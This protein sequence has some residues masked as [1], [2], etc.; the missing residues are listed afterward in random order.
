MSHRN[1]T[2]FSKAPLPAVQTGRIS[3]KATQPNPLRQ[4]RALKRPLG[5]TLRANPFPEVTDP[6]CRLPL[7][8][9]FYWTRGCTPWRPDAVMST[10]RHEDILGNLAQIF[11]GRRE[12]SGHKETPCALPVFNPSRRVNRFQGL[13]TVNKK[14]E[15]SP[16]LPPTSSSSIVL[17]PTHVLAT[18]Y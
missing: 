16:G 1:G 2:L 18:E 13:W 6:F 11:K 15:L 4:D 5:S 3:P 10:P 12:R 9:L 8:T 14:R 17:P 7:S